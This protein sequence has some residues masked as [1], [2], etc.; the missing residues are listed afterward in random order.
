MKYGNQKSTNMIQKIL[1]YLS[2]IFIAIIIGMWLGKKF[3]VP[4]IKVE[5]NSNVVIEK[6]E[7]VAK[8]ITVETQLSEIYNYKDYY[9]YD[10]SFLRKKI[11]L[12]INA[13]VSAGYDLKKMN[14]VV[15]TKQKVIKLGPIPPPQ[16]LSV[17]HTVDYFNIEEGLFNNFTP[18]D[19][20]KINAKAKDYIT[21]VA[22]NSEVIKTA[23]LQENTMIEMMTAM[24]KSMGY[25]LEI[26]TATALK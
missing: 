8:L 12:R 16:I 2:V 1:T 11:L 13:K 3:F 15:D 24:A 9:D 21:K 23:K 20:T 7:K 18:E 10:F 25:N 6:I 4:D 17:D 19:Y 26:K 14:L 5:E 22:N